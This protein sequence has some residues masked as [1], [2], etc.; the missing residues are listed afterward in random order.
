MN[1][2]LRAA[3]EDATGIVRQAVFIDE[4]SE[5]IAKEIIQVALRLA[6]EWA[7]NFPASTHGNLSR[8]PAA[9]SR[10]TADEIAAAIRQLISQLEDSNNG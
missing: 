9:A 10:Q 1:E 7:D 4:P 2:Q 5:D 6:A 3:V 8:I